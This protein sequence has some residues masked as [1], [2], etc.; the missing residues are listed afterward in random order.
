MQKSLARAIRLNPFAIED[1]LWDG[2]LAGVGDDLVGGA[3]GALDIDFD[4]GDCVGVEKTLGLAAV[5]A[6]VC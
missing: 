4:E 3:G 1:E 6:P 5:A 2:A